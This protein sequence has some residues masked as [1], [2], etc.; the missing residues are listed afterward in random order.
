LLEMGKTP[1]PK[2]GMVGTSDANTPPPPPHT[3]THTEAAWQPETN[4]VSEL[5]GM[6]IEDRPTW[7][8]Y[9]SLAGSLDAHG[10]NERIPKY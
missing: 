1:S 9:R 8:Q 2:M 4:A 3:H 10:R 6:D 7:K 5:H